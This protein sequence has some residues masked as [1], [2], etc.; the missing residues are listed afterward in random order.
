MEFD[1]KRPDPD[2]LLKKFAVDKASKKGKLK[3]FLGYAAGVGK[4][5]AMLDDAHGQLKSGVDV[6][7]GYVEPHHPARNPSAACRDT[8]DSACC[9]ELQKHTTQ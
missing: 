4:T 1:E 9:G 8:S 2:L 5:Y 7:V 3:I 6:V